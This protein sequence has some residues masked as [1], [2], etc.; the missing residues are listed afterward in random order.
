MTTIIDL[1]YTGEPYSRV[2]HKGSYLIECWGAEGGSWDSEKYGGRGAY[3]SGVLSISKAIHLHFYVGQKGST[4]TGREIS[5][6]P[7]TFNGGGSGGIPSKP[8]N[9]LYFGSSG[10]GA[11]DI[12]TIYGQWNDTSSLESRI[13]VAA[14]GG[15]ATKNGVTSDCCRGGFGGA[16][17]G[18]EGQKTGASD[19]ILIATGGGQDSSLG[20]GGGSDEYCYGTDGSLGKGGNG[21]NRIATSGGGGG[22]YGGG[23]SGVAQSNHQCGAGGSSYISGHKGLTAMDLYFTKTLMISGNSDITSYNG[24]VTRGNVGDGHIRVTILSIHSHKCD[25][26]LKL[27]MNTY[28]LFISIFSFSVS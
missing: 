18:G 13:I 22:Y 10:G 20:K 9:T 28:L 12:R 23:G 19:N 24:D 7:P 4:V 5:I 15:G 14:G 17:I 8:S 21:G 25:K 2:L 16:T 6:L 11:C 26:Q 3:V 1:N 27:F